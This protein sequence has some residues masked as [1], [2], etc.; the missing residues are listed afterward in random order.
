MMSTKKHAKSKF[1]YFSWCKFMKSLNFFY[2]CLRFCLHLSSEFEFN[3][4]RL[5]LFI[6]TFMCIM[7][8][9]F[10][11]FQELKFKFP[12][13]LSSGMGTF[14]FEQCPWKL[15]QVLIKTKVY[16]F[17]HLIHYFSIKLTDLRNKKI[18]NFS[19]KL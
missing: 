14:I 5:N 19:E 3:I 17:V 7:C 10:K 4:I 13:H 11:Y 2:V 9:V 15:Y 6:I 12:K 8:N 1:A 16:T 18:L